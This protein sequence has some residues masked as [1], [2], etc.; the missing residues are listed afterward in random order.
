MVTNNLKVQGDK[1]SNITK[2][3]RPKTWEHLY[4]PPLSK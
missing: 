4:I 1:I 3:L 2:M